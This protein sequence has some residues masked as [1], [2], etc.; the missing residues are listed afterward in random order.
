MEPVAWVGERKTLLAM[1]FSLWCL[2]CYVRH[3]RRGGW[4]WLTLSAVSYVL[5]VLSKPT[6]VPIPALLLLMDYWPLRRLSP[7][8]AA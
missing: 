4:K 3:A 7:A 2:L 1:F 8:R 5:A 6:A